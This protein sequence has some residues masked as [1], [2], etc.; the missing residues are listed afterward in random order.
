MSE[1]INHCGKMLSLLHLSWKYRN[2]LSNNIFITGHKKVVSLLTV[3]IG[4]EDH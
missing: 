1:M 3:C 4:D 2:Y